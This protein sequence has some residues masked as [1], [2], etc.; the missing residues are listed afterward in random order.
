MPSK[1]DLHDLTLAQVAVLQ[2]DLMQRLQSAPSLSDYY[3]SL[4]LTPAFFESLYALGVADYQAGDYESARLHLS[5]L[6]RLQPGEPRFSKA[7][8]T[9]LQALQQY[10]SA[11][12]HYLDALQ[13]RPDD[14]SI[15]FYSAQCLLMLKRQ[16]DAHRVLQALIARPD[17]Q[18]WH[19]RAKALLPLSVPHILFDQAKDEVQQ[20]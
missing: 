18:L 13:G 20:N 10:E 9:T 17:A 19:D 7:M 15:L 6:L 12:I 14:L 3:A 11:L 1:A 8:G 2:S 16:D 4:G 5:K